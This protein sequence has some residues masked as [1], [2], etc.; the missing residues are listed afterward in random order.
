MHGRRVR[1]LPGK[2]LDG[3]VEMDQNF[4]LGRDELEC[5]LCADLPVASDQPVRI[6]RRRRQK[7]TNR[8]ETNENDF[9][10][11]DGSR[12]S[13]RSTETLVCA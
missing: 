12:S 9:A 11:P 1:H 2:V 10:T 4:A 3:T 13:L 5:Q 6:R 7:E 8:P